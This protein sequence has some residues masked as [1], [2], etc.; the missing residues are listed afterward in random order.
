V[1]LPHDDLLAPLPGEAK[2]ENLRYDPVYDKI[3]D[4]RQEEEEDGSNQG[5]WQRTRKKADFNAVIKLASSALAGK[6]KDLQIAVWLAEA[7]IRK[8]GFAALADC[9]NF[10]RE[11]QDR[12]WDNLYP[13]LEDGDAQFRATPQEWLAGR[14]DH[15]LRRIALTKKGFDWFK[16][17][18][19]RDTS[20]ERLAMAGKASEDV[21]RAAREQ[22][23]AFREAAAQEFNQSFEA[24]P[25]AF[26][27]AALEQLKAAQ[28]ALAELDAFCDQ[29]YGK[30]AP[31]F[32]KLRVALE[33]VS[34]A[35]NQL[36]DKKR[37]K[38]PD[39]VPQ[40]EVAEQTETAEPAEEPVTSAPGKAA[41]GLA[42][43]PT[44]P[45]E[46]FTLI[47]RAAEFLRNSDPSLVA[48]YM[49]VRALRWA[50]LRA[51]GDSLDPALLVAPATELRQ[52]LRR[53][54]L[55]QEWGE[56]LSATEA[57]TTLPCGRAWI[58]LHRYACV[59]LRELC[60]ST[61]AQAICSGLRALIA[62]YPSLPESILDDGTPVASSDT[63]NWLEEYVFPPKEPEPVSYVPP[64]SAEPAPDEAAT[65]GAAD[66]F[67]EALQLA[68][69]QQFPKAI[70]LMTQQ[71]LP[72][73]SGRQRFLR[74]LKISQLCLA[75]GQFSIAYPIL[76]DLFAE[77]EQ[78]K[79]LE[80]ESTK[81]LVQPLSL[82]VRCIDKTNQ[83]GEKRAEIYNLLCR[84]EPAE[85]LR[86]QNS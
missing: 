27:V 42:A 4:A 29:K 2:G 79:L 35:V 7:W 28:D 63:K 75:T 58:D 77:I 18:D 81:F 36:L 51:G 82:L 5:E 25:K 49:V 23:I 86:L 16:Y 45:D 78:R 12:F 43:K 80:W 85:A 66:P 59:A 84:L 72:E 46:A 57:A 76:R 20:R 22:A 24:T 9:F 17:Y 83:G 14:C 15:L 50:E 65:N 11:L 38:E 44:T 73:D 31:N 21:K 71:R 6:S 32:A 47:T 55:N 1:S 13:E 64:R 40:T 61:V 48:P 70:E 56:L 33:D 41:A 26:Y 37:E 54:F 53:L 69:E 10:L 34:Q 8:D 62:D 3:K 52:N 39:E 60:Y 67:E 30:V 68:R 74:Q 19:G